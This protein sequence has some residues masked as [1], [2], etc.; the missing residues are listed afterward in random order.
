MK[1]EDCFQLGYIVKPHGIHG[2]LTIYLDTDNPD[3]YKELESVYVEYQQKLVPFFIDHIKIKDNQATV[4]FQ[5][6]DG[7]E[8]ASQY[9]GCTLYL[10]LDFLPPLGSGQFYYHD[11][12]G[13]IAKERNLGKLGE[14]KTIYE[15][16]GND[17]FSV[18][19]KGKEVLIP[20]RDE[21]V[22]ELN[23]EAR[24]I[25]LELPDG[26]IDIYLNS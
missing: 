13:F 26:L 2:A 15:A 12:I 21:F 10:P 11:I 1:I 25:L 9:K 7:I 22:I 8:K 24:E 19:Y 17:L 6:I 3:Y 4:E 23:K 18:L 20:I 14:V 16:N 5:D